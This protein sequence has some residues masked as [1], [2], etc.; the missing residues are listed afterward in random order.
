MSTRPSY[1]RE[2]APGGPPS[3]ADDELMLRLRTASESERAAGFE[4]IV[5]RH[6]NAIMSY[7]YRFVGD[8]RTAEDLAQE[9]FLRVFRKLADYQPGAKFTTW[10]YTIASNLAKDEFKRRVRHPA[11]SMDWQGGTGADTTRNVPTL[12]SEATPAPEERLEQDET[13]RQ[14]AAALD[15][16]KEEDREIIVLKDVQGLAYEEIA[17]I[18]KLPV[19]TVKSRL[20][21]ARLA[22]KDEWKRHAP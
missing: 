11:Q 9:A 15:G 12:I 13:R 19:G 18:L 7:L 21:R 5:R 10:L 20:S 14:I 8:W 16:L 22:F 2:T 4:T 1:Q 6:K 17:E 3:I